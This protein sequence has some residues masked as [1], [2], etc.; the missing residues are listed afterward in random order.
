ACKTMLGNR[1]L[2]WQGMILL[3]V[4]A[5]HYSR[6][7]KNGCVNMFNKASQKC[8]ILLAQADIAD[9]TPVEQLNLIVN[10]CL[11]IIETGKSP[12][13]YIHKSARTIVSDEWMDFQS[14]KKN[15]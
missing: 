6:G 3:T 12:L 13:P 11:Q 8:H 1:R 2:F 15:L 9:H 7:N 5:Y 14:T 4:G 10:T